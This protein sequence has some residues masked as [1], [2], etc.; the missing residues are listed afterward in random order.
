MGSSRCFYFQLTL[1]TEHQGP[2]SEKRKTN[3]S[4]FLRHLQN[5][6]ENQTSSQL[7]IGWLKY[8]KFNQ[9]LTESLG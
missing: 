9:L 8:G 7:M 6:V 2:F 5:E 4:E 3:E 1:P